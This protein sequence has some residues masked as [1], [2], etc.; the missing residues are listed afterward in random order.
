MTAK[1]R[2]RGNT[3]ARE[4]IKPLG[5]QNYTP[6]WVPVRPGA[7]DHEAVPSLHCGRRFYRDG[8]VEVA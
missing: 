7:Q 1:G 3:R 8:R 4:V 5:Q 6:N 2:R